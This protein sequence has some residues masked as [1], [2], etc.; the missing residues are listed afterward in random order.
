MYIVYRHCKTSLC[1]RYPCLPSTSPSLP[2]PS[3]FTSSLAWPGSSCA[4]YSPPFLPPFFFPAP[5]HSSYFPPPARAPL[6]PLPVHPLLVT[7]CLPPY[8]PPFPFTPSRPPIQLQF[9]LSIRPPPLSSILPFSVP[10]ATTH[11]KNIT[12]FF[13]IHFELPGHQS[14]NWEAM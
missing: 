11:T 13:K 4:P 10:P 9:P 12:H 8:F 5:H 1:L 3:W 14:W 7:P 6:L 2:A